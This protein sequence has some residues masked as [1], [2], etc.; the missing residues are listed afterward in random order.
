METL[1]DLQARVIDLEMIIANQDRTLDDLNT[2]IIRQGRIIE[3]LTT[4]VTQIQNRLT[5][6]AIRAQAEETPP[7]HY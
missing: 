2:E 4:H 6:S 1:T 3:M 7:P 5:E